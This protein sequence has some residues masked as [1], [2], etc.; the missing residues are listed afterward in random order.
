M[1]VFLDDVS[2]RVPSSLSFLIGKFKLDIKICSFR[3]QTFLADMARF[4]FYLE[5]KCMICS[6][7]KFCFRDLF[8]SIKMFYDKLK[9]PV[10]EATLVFRHSTLA[11]LLVGVICVDNKPLKGFIFLL[12]VTFLQTSLKLQTIHQLSQSQRRA[13]SWL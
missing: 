9:L 7:N 10:P 13:F 6:A 8:I 5:A 11:S 1:R 12:E 3:L 4:Y 2:I